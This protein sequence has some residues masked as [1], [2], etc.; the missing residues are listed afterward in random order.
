MK[1]L[2]LRKSVLNK[3][4]LEAIAPEVQRGPK[5][6][7]QDFRNRSTATTAFQI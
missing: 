4:G 5:A 6:E 7:K 2:E 3:P 1:F